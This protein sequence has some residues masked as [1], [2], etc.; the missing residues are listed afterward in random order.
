MRF[1]KFGG[2]ENATRLL[3]HWLLH[4]ARNKDHPSHMDMKMP[5]M[6]DIRSLEEIRIEHRERPRVMHGDRLSELHVNAQTQ[7]SI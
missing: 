1:G 5:A 3:Q 6:K 7:A 2:E 4:A